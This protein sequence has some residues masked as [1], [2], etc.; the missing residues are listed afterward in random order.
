VPIVTWAHGIVI[1][2]NPGITVPGRGI[3]W[4]CVAVHWNWR[5]R[6]VI[7]TAT[8]PHSEKDSW[9][10]EYATAGQQKKGKNFC[11]HLKLLAAIVCKS[12]A[13]LK[14]LKQKRK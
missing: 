3:G 4:S 10:S 14:L 6:S 9:T 8:E 13:R 5:R 2:R 1:T 12:F 11:F 7:V